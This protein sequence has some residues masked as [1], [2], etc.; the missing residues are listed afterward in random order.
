MKNRY[1]LRT[2][3][4]EETFGQVVAGFCAGL[5]A[6]ETYITINE[7]GNKVSRQTVETKFLELGS[8]FYKKWTRPAFV[9]LMRQANPDSPMPDVDL[10]IVALHM[11][12]AEFRGETG[13]K[14]L[15]NAKLPPPGPPEL[16]KAMQARWKEFNGFTK[17]TFRC[18]LGFVYYSL[19]PNVQQNPEGGYKRVMTIL[20]RE[21]LDPQTVFEYEK[22]YAIWV[23]EEDLPEGQYP[24]NGDP[25][26]VLIPDPT[27]VYGVEVDLQTRDEPEA[28]D[29]A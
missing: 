28:G 11:L 16:I 29:T 12:W 25:F 19:R 20:E 15:R 24:P 2:K 23:S 18:Q 3:L 27:S 14:E 17:D 22:S 6:T 4:D 9:S 13:Y 10:E 5:T 21:P 8:Y 7:L 1:C 26:V